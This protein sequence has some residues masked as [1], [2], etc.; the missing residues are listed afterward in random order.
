MS[1]VNGDT[2]RA[3]RMR[4]Q[5]LKRRAKKLQVAAPASKPKK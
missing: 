4:K 1:L 2:S 3:H 5:K